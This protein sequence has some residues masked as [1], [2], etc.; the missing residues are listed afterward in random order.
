MSSQ[1]SQI[2]ETRD[3]K[4]AD[5]SIL[6][7]IPGGEGGLPAL[8][9]VTARGQKYQKEKYKL[10]SNSAPTKNKKKRAR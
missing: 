10:D 2:V 6:H 5:A 9:A 4:S 7:G 3:I 8:G 1:P